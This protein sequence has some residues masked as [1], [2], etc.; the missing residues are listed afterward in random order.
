MG[1]IEVDEEKLKKFNQWRFS[2]LYG[3]ELSHF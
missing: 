3:F 1:R 2:D